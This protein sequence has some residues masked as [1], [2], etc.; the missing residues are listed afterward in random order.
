MNICT[1]KPHL[2]KA[3]KRYLQ[4]YETRQTNKKWKQ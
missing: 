4:G 1:S 2:R 3:E